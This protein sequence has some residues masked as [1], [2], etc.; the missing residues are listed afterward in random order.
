[1]K[2][3]DYTKDEFILDECFLF[4]EGE[5]N[6]RMIFIDE[7]DVFHAVDSDGNV[8]YFKY[9]VPI[10]DFT[11]E[12]KRKVIKYNLGDEGLWEEMYAADVFLHGEYVVEINDEIRCN[13]CFR[14][15]SK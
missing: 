5:R 12:M 13:N 8:R 9:T 3:L 6:P 11:E 1:M 10:E 14:K 7:D 4:D 15:H 2:T